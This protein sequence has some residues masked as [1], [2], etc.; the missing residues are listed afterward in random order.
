VVH[1]ADP[2]GGLFKAGVHDAAVGDVGEGD[3]SGDQYDRKNYCGGNAENAPPRQ[4]IPQFGSYGGR[5][6]MGHFPSF[7][8]RSDS[9]WPGRVH[10]RVNVSTVA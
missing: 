4:N 1:D 2:A 10:L 5:T 9:F 3:G 7:A 6:P 8:A